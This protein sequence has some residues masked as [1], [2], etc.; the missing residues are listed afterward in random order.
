[1]ARPRKLDLDEMRLQIIA[2]ARQML[3]EKDISALTARGLAQRVGLPAS[4]L[5]RIFPTMAEVVMAVNEAT[6][7]EIDALFEALPQSSPLERFTQLAMGYLT[8]MRENPSLWRALFVDARRQED[9]PDWYLQAIKGLMG[10]LSALL[11]A[12]CPEVPE[13]IVA[14]AT[15]RLFVFAHGAISLELDGRLGLITPLSSQ[16]IALAA[17]ESTLAQI[18]RAGKSL[19]IASP[20]LLQS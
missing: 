15:G 18:S 17:I 4:A 3:C 19:K 12:V 7:K 11:G 2:A 13:P 6:F 16:E 10:R 8:F 9:Y 14:D 20:E 1:M 5:Y